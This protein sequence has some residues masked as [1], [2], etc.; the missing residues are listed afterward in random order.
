[1]SGT[2]FGESVGAADG[3]GNDDVADTPD[4]TKA[5]SHTDV[6]NDLTASDVEGAKLDD[7]LP[8]LVGCVPLLG[9]VTLTASGKHVGKRIRVTILTRI[10]HVDV[11]KHIDKRVHHPQHL[12]NRVTP[13]AD[14]KEEQR[15]PAPQPF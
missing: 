6:H 10:D 8:L 9:I 5:V 13:I 3:G 15:I 12:H 1:M 2:I 14:R 4:D 11:V 7:V